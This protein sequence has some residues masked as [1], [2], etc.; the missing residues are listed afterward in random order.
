M[1]VLP[2]ISIYIHY[3]WCIKKCPYCD[4]N[5]HEGE[6]KDSYIDSL[7]VDLENDIDYLQKRSVSSIFIGGGTPSLMKAKDVDKIIKK[8]ALMANLKEDIEITMECNPSSFEAEK[9]AKFR[10]AGV[11]RISIGV[12][13][14]LNKN[15]QNLQRIHSSDEAIYS[16]KKAKEVGFDNIN[17]D[18]MYALENQALDECLADVKKAI[19]FNT[20]HISF[21]QLNIE[22]NTLF[23][24]FPPTLPNEDDVWLMMKKA[25]KMLENNDYKQYEISAFGKTI[26]SHNMNYWQFGDYLGIGAGAHGKITKAKDN[27]IFRTA[28]IKSPKDYIKKYQNNNANE[29]EIKRIYNINFEFMLNALR[30]KDGFSLELFQSR[31]GNLYS[32]I[33]EKVKKAQDLGLLKVEKNII[34]PTKKGFNFINDL[35]EMFL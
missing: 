16:I 25:H 26:C 29:N 27:I 12:Q 3:P 30:L 20:S 13:S 11:N 24:K 15:L 10:S 35:Q 4:F 33:E 5:S 21:Y 32:S 23:A 19:D 22:K 17:I 6:I 18:L 8:I 9:F 7:L 31:T 28:K 2:P 1:L 34:M 14:F